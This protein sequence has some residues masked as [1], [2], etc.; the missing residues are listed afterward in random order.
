VSRDCGVEATTP[1]QWAVTWNEPY[2]A[3]TVAAG[4]HRSNTGW[5]V[6]HDFFD[7]GR[8]VV[9]VVGQSSKVCELLADGPSDANAMLG[10]PLLKGCLEGGE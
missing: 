2:T 3:H 9:E 10:F 4:V 6:G 8:T 7:S 5:F 1:Y